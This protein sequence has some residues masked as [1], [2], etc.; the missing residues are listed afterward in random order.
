MHNFV[1]L[2]ATL[3]ALLTE[4]LWWMMIYYSHEKSISDVIHCWNWNTYVDWNNNAYFPLSANR[5]LD[6]LPAWH[7]W[8]WNTYVHRNNS[9][10]IID[11]SVTKERTVISPYLS[12]QQQR[13]SFSHS[14]NHFIN[15]TSKGFG[16]V[17]LPWLNRAG[18]LDKRK[19]RNT[20]GDARNQTPNQWPCVVHCSTNWPTSPNYI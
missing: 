10:G 20:I 17:S 9:L 2:D 11:T 4:L 12:Q 1:F 16:V 8:N 5:C 14:Q 6:S 3:I 13:D 19:N 15:P 7:C 18:D